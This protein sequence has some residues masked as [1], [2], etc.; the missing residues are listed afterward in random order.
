MSAVRELRDW[1]ASFRRFDDYNS[2]TRLDAAADELERWEKATGG[3]DR[4]L[5]AK[6]LTLAADTRLT[7]VCNEFGWTT[8]EAGQFLAALRTA[9]FETT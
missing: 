5:V 6:A 7:D 2:S 4:A 8:T 3:L 1:A 9:T